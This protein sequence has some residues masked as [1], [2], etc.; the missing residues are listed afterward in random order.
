M[1]EKVG[2]DSFAN[3]IT[4]GAQAHRRVLTPLQ[5]QVRAIVNLAAGDRAR[6]P[7][8]GR[9]A[10]A[11]GRDLPFVETVRLSTVVIALVPNGLILS[12]AL[13]YALGAIRMAG[14]G[15]L[16]Q[17]ANAVESLSNVDVLC[18]DKTG[19]LTTNVI[20]LH[21]LEPLAGSQGAARN[22]ARRL[23][24][25]R[26]RA[27][28]GRPRRWPRPSRTGVRRLVGSRLLVAAQVERPGVRRRSSRR[29][30]ADGGGGE[31]AAAPIRGTYVLG[32]PEVLRPELVPGSALG[33]RLGEWTSAGHR[34]LLFA[35][36]AQ[37]VAFSPDDDSPPRLPHDLVPLGL[38]MPQRRAAAQRAETLQQFA[39]AGIARQ[40]HLRRQPA[41]RRLARSQA[42]LGADIALPSP[43]SNSRHSSEPV[44]A[45]AAERRQ[46]VRPRHTRAEAEADRALR[47]DGHY[48]AMIGDGVN[49]VVSLK[50]RT[51]ASP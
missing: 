37:P 21:D 11:D 17:Q 26:R 51:W 34:V 47:A 32:A 45:E 24:G 48:V 43:A 13:A 16:V 18:T 49:D 4:A 39:E 29:R 15:T 7:G 46:R 25:Q 10:L 30:A 27:G 12:I 3:R 14:Q 42:G 8:D 40:S 44:L 19:T 9:G 1:A 6:L 36:L 31:S 22:D 33:D 35:T 41:D 38:V 2:A 23:R 28:T 50:G 5:H 20:R